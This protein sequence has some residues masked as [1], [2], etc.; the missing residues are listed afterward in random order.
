GA[1]APEAQGWVALT[2]TDTGVGMTDETRRRIFHPFFTTKGVKRFGL[3]LALV[4]GTMERHG[5]K[6]AVS[7]TPGHGTAFTLRFRRARESD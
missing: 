2:V 6:I 5:S 1:G 4:Y 3:G 7:S